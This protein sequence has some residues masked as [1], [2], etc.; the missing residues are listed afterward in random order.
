MSAPTTAHWAA[1]KRILRYLRS[2]SDLGLRLTMSGSSLLS[3]L[4]DA[5]WAGDLDNRRSMGGY[6]V[7]LGGNL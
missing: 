7:F 6:T 1:V 2:T 5:D 3:A 4:S